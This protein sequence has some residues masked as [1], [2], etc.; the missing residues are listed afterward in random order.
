MR[1]AYNF[2]NAV[3]NPYFS[4]LKESIT[5]SVNAET[6]DYFKRIADEKGMEYRLLINLY[7]EDCAKNDGLRRINK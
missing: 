6:I 4:K 2:S 5:V 7:L 1:K 3:K